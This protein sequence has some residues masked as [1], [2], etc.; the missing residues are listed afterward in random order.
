MLP[1]DVLV[2]Q[3]SAEIEM[4]HSA[5]AK[6]QKKLASQ[7]DLLDRQSSEIRDLTFQLKEMRR[8]QQSEVKQETKKVTHSEKRAATLHR[9]LGDLSH[10]HEVAMT[11]ASAAMQELQ[12]ERDAMAM[13]LAAVATQA[14]SGCPHVVF[15][16]AVP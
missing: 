9:K 2:V 15:Q 3:A 16:H 5:N 7:R 11:A 6:L 12:N 14:V 10:E 1:S 4:A 8:M 13:G